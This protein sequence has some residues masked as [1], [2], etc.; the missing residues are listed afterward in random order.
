MSEAAGGE[1]ELWQKAIARSENLMKFSRVRRTLAPARPAGHE[2]RDLLVTST[3][4]PR[5]SR[6]LNGLFTL[7]GNYK[8][9]RGYLGVSSVPLFTRCPKRFQYS[10]M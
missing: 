9:R 7:K 2:K 3:W 10:Q 5:I 8:D 1:N 4:S 6:P